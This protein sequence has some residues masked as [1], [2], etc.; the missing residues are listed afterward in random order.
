MHR[1]TTTASILALSLST[2]LGAQE[3]P[4]APAAPV[5]VTSGTGEVRIAPDRA[6]V[7][8][9][10]E[11]K[12][13][14]AA[15]TASTNARIQQRVLDTLA[16]LG[17]R[18]PDVSTLS[19]NVSPYVEETRTGSRQSGYV[20]RNAVTVRL[21]NLSRIGAVID[22]ALARGA[23]TVEDVAFTSTKSDSANRVAVAAAAA[24]ARA[25]A[26]ALAA[27]LGGRIGE[28]LE[29][30]SNG[31]SGQLFAMLARRRQAGYGMV[32]TNASNAITPSDLLIT[33]GVSTRWRFVSNGAR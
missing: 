15:T 33:A 5:I 23:T 17:L 14:S 29:A 19:F 12:G 16:A 2:S 3:G 9:A 25:Q 27:S 26:E 24:D 22:A 18:A 20:A 21:T 1:L 8:L 13:T 32:E 10:V 4:T 11:T 7:T 31:E 6:T 30:S 28:L